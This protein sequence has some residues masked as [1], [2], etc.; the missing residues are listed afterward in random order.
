[1]L[2]RLL[3]VFL[4]IFSIFSL[5]AHASQVCSSIPECQDL[6]KQAQIRIQELSNMGGQRRVSITG[7][8]FT[9]DTSVP[10]LGE[11]YRDPDPSGL[12]WGSIAMAQGKVNKMNQSLAERYCKE[13]G[14]RLPTKEELEQLAKYLGK[15]TVQGY[16][17]YLAD[18]KTEF[19]PGLS[20]YSIWSS[21]SID[22]YFVHIF[23]GGYITSGLRATKGAVL[24]VADR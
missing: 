15:G 14:A 20:S 8:V 23:S 7:A 1:M 13:G 3:P 5:E 9:G 4:L 21:S 10:A 6:I 18:G 11:A 22:S 17:P 24:C 19:L 12:I 16:S 2:D